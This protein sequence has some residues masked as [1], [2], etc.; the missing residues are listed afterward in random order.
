M[1]DLVTTFPE[2]K[3]IDLERVQLEVFSA[4]SGRPIVLC[5]G[6]PEHAFSWRYQIQPL[7]DAGYHVIVPNQRGYGRSSK[8]ENVTDYDITHLTDDLAALLDHY[9]Y[10]EALFT[11][12]DWGAIVVWN[13]AM[14]QS[15]RV[16][17]VINLS[18]P[19]MARGTSEWVGFW[20]EMLGGDFYI[21]HFNRQPGVADAAFAANCENFLRNLYRTEQWLEAPAELSG[22]P[23]IAIAEHPGMPGRLMMSEAELKVFVDAFQHAGFTGGLNWYRNFSRNWEIIGQYEQRIKQ[24]TLMIHGQY[25]MVPASPDLKTYVPNAEVHTLPCGHWIQQEQPA[26][27]NELMLNWLARHYP[28]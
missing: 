12:H 14:L 25:D 23:M 19:F 9:G 2:A 18:V 6:W 27:T 20:E 24:P 16:S 22:N 1:S 26:A 10:D 17:G 28:A 5:H 11:G 15:A 3:I 21:V 4:G 13:M 7:V 8:P